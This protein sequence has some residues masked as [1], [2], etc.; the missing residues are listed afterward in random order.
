[1]TSAR[2]LDY[3]LTGLSF[4]NSRYAL[5]ANYQTVVHTD[6]RA[7]ILNMN[8]SKINYSNNFF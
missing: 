6:H 7:I 1:M 5:D 2:R 3:I 4:S 8:D